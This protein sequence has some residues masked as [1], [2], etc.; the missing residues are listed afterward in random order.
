MTAFTV[1]TTSTATVDAD[2]AVIWAALT[3]PD[4]L[5]RLTPYL[6]SIEATEDNGVHRWRWQLTRI[7]VL[8]RALSPSFSE[9]MTFYEPTAITFTHDPDR[10]EEKSGVEGSYHLTE[11]ARGTDL[12]IDLA[13][14]IDLPFP[15]LARP[16]VHPAMRAVVAAMGRRFSTNL[17]RYLERRR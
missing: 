2:R 14:T 16:A 13:I 11:V 17:V 15:G 12:R 8:G 6:S 9:V 4:L 5:P 10:I 3:D 1:S 7:P